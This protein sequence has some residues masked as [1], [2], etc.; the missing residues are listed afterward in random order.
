MEQAFNQ[1]SIKLQK[2]DCLYMFSDG[3]AD[4]FG[5]PKGKKFMYGKLKKYLLEIHQKEMND[6]KEL[7]YQTFQDWK[8]EEAQ[9]DDVIIIGIRV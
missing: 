8:G 3:Y 9:V 7:L 1:E 5:G 2:G 4:Q 6:Q